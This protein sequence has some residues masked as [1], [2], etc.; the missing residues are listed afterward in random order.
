MQGDWLPSKVTKEQV[1]ELVAD[2][3]VPEVGWRLPEPR[4][5][6]PTPH[7]DE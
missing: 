7:Q 1:L 3:L 4:D 5:A 6:E 2:G